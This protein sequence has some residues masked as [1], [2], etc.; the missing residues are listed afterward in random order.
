MQQQVQPPDSK[1]TSWVGRL[2]LWA[3][4]KLPHQL[5]HR[6]LALLV[7]AVLVRY[8]VSGDVRLRGANRR[9]KHKKIFLEKK[10]MPRKEQDEPDAEPK[11]RNCCSAISGKIFRRSMS[12]VSGKSRRQNSH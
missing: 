5:P 1:S 9:R 8:C 2:E 11:G 12:D 4:N 6:S 10:F 7:L 3:A